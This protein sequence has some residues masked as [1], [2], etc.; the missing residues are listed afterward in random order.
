MFFYLSGMSAFTS[1]TQ[2]DPTNKV[3]S[4]RLPLSVT[5]AMLVVAVC[6]PVALAAAIPVAW[7]AITPVAAG[8][9]VAAARKNA[10]S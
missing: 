1:I 7:N 3:K 10:N 5:A 6:P 8:V 9:L 2:A 4:D